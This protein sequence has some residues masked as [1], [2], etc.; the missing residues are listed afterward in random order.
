MNWTD[1]AII[2][3]TY[4]HGE[5]SAIATM[6][7]LEHGLF[8]GLVRN[9]SSKNQRGTYEIGNL[10][11]ASWRGRLIE[12]LGNFS[13]ELIKSN[14]SF[15]MS[16]PIKLM[17]LTSICSI[18]QKSLPER[19]P[20]SDI[21]V[22]LNQLIENITQ[23]ENAQTEIDKTNLLLNTLNLEWLLS[24]SLFELELL[25][26]A[27]FGLDLS[28]CVATEKTEDLEY[29]SPKSG[30]A[31]S[32]EAGKPYHSKLFR[33]PKYFLPSSQEKEKNSF[34]DIKLEEIINGLEISSY[35]LEK[36]IFKQHNSK[37]PAARLQFAQKIKELSNIHPEEK[38][39]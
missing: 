4:K 1:N 19:E 11:E 25:S 14:S 32:S 2:I 21:F 3:S 12:H 8:K 31:V 10:V 16:C 22:L 27:G 33:M 7:T 15:L 38:V 30:C 9:I 34:S 39:S 24:Y 18:L 29:I 36:Y 17:A 37:I 6:L 35:F 26:N 23:S 20:A 5:S 28:K 13:S